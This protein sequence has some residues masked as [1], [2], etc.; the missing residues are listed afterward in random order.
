MAKKMTLREKKER[1]EV[2]KELREMGLLPEKKKPLNRKK[3]VEEVRNEYLYYPK[4]GFDIVSIT[5]A[6]G[7]MYPERCKEKITS[8]DIGIAKLVKA[9]IE[10]DKLDANE[11]V[12]ID[13]IEKKITNPLKKL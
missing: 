8:E 2:R 6:I 11:K 5:L 10:I 3:F 4:V 13:E 9:I 1:E 12:N 7:F